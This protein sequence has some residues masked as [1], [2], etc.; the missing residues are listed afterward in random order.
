M[1]IQHM[2]LHKIKKKPQFLCI[3]HQSQ[4]DKQK[5]L[6]MN[7][8]PDKQ[9]FIRGEKSTINSITKPFS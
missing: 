8:N 9:N 2:S 5:C 3:T 7:N 1:L 6:K 4:M